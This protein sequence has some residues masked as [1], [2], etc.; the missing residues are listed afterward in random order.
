MV[1]MLCIRT[2]LHSAVSVNRVNSPA[3]SRRMW[4]VN[5]NRRAYPFLLIVGVVILLFGVSIAA[6]LH[7]PLP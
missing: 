5:V 4:T 6:V 1:L 7:G 3:L 2:F